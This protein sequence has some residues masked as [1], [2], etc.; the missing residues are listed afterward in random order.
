M[1][2]ACSCYLSCRP[3]DIFK[4]ELKRKP[5]NSTLRGKSTNEEPFIEFNSSFHDKNFSV[6]LKKNKP[7]SSF[8]F[9]KVPCADSEKIRV[10]QKIHS[11]ARSIQEEV[12]LEG[13]LEKYKPIQSPL[14]TPRWCR[15]TA[16]SFSY[17]KNKWSTLH[18]PLYY[19]PL[20]MLSSVKIVKNR[21]QKKNPELFEFELIISGEEEYN[22]AKKSK[23]TTREPSFA[24]F[25]IVDEEVLV[26]DKKLLF[27]TKDHNT[28]QDWVKAFKTLLE[29]D[30]N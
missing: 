19:I 10:Y 21:I 8:A 25:G 7:Q 3:N 11:P 17:F 29:V 12:I 23:N 1:G 6:Q 14:Y 22:S 30:T 9:L 4:Q 20:S 2:N 26:G 27:G 28:F 5:L 18:S 24:S 16:Q 15:L 13:E